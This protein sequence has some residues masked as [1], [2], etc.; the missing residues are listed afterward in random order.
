MEKSDDFP[1]AR[2]FAHKLHRALFVL[3]QIRESQNPPQHRSLDRN[4]PGSTYPREF[5]VQTNGATSVHDAR[6]QPIYTVSVD[7]KPGVQ[8]LGLTAPDL[9]P[10]PDKAATLGRD[11]EYVRHGTVSLLAGIDR[12]SGHI[13]ERVEDRQRS[14][15]FM[16]LLKDI[17]AHYPP[18]AIVRLVLDNHSAHISKETRAFLARHAP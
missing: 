6:R 10:I 8:A 1:T 16:E 3:Y 18:E 9:P 2:P 17:N 4:W 11:Y 7:E 15:E 12:H 14:A 13:F 5:P